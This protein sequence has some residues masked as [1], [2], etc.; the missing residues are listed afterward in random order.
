MIH[1]LCFELIVSW[2]DDKSFTGNVSLISD[3]WTRY[4]RKYLARPTG[5][6]Q[7]NKDY[8]VFRK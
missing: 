3:F 5:H 4:I 1:K 8:S 6:L 2:S 7:L